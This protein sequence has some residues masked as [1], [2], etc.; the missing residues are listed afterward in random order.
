[1]AKEPSLGQV[2]WNGIEQLTP[3]LLSLSVPDIVKKTRAPGVCRH[4]PQLA[5]HE[6][7]DSNYGA[8]VRAKLVTPLLLKRVF[9]SVIKW[10]AVCKVGHR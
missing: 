8:V 9:R 10:G 1:L 4:Q 5:H 7:N 3:T 2:Q 6:E